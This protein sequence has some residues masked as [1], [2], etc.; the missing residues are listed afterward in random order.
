MSSFSG[1]PFA[2]LHKFWFDNDMPAQIDKLK[3]Q[4]Q[5]LKREKV[6]LE[7]CLRLQEEGLRVKGLEVQQAVA[8]KGRVEEDVKGLRA[9]VER[10]RLEA[11]HEKA[12]KECLATEMHRYAENVANERTNAEVKSGTHDEWS[13]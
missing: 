6:D 3:R 7:R 8:A 5:V 11:G 1:C 4:C 12:E 2:I 13:R 10:W 9:E